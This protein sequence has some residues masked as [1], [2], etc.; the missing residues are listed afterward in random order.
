MVFV[1]K[2]DNPG[3]LLCEN[4]I[5]IANIFRQAEHLLRYRSAGSGF[6][7]VQIESY[8]TLIKSDP[9]GNIDHM[10]QK[11]R[12]YIRDKGFVR[13]YIERKWL[14]KLVKPGVELG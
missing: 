11:K 1:E 2:S 8:H 13:R 5:Y 6:V 12:H 7:W 9:S 10:H 4:C 3:Y 14:R